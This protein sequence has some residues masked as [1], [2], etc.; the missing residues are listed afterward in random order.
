MRA[1]APSPGRS[2]SV[3]EVASLEIAQIAKDLAD[4]L[5]VAYNASEAVMAR[6]QQTHAV[7][8]RVYQRSVSFFSTNETVFTALSATHTSQL[9]LHESTE[10]LNAMTE[11]VSKGLEAI[12]ETGDELLKKGLEAGYGSTIRVDAVKKLVDSVVNFQTESLKLIEDHRA[13]ATKDAAEIAGY[14][15]EGKRKFAALVA[16]APQA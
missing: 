8:N 16:P 11:G 6:L 1:C 12:A 10:T 4:N 14:V 5:Q 2:R 15:E 7:K 9:G 13:Q 3:D